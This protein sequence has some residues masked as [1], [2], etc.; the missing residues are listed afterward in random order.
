MALKRIESDVEGSIIC[1]H[2]VR[3]V[4]FKILRRSVPDVDSFEKWIIARIKGATRLIEF[5]GELV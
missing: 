3:I 4:P 2:R 1:R 5:V